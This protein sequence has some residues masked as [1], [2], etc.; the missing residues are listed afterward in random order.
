MKRLTVLLVAVLASGCTMFRPIAA[1]APAM[2][3]TRAGVEAEC[4]LRFRAAANV[5]DSIAVLDVQP[6]CRDVLVTA[7]R[8][9]PRATPTPPLGL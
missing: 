7:P 1:S 5:K 4:R 3:D 2:G 8:T 6:W 9:V